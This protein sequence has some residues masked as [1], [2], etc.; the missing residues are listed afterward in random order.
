MKVLFQGTAVFILFFFVL[1]AC[2]K[3]THSSVVQQQLPPPPPPAPPTGAAP[4]SG[5]WTG[6]I[7][8]TVQNPDLCSWNGGT[9]SITQNW[10]VVGDSVHVEDILKDNGGTYTYYWLGTIKKDTL[11]MI[12]KRNINCFGEVKSNEIVVKA[13]ISSLVDKYSIQTSALYSPCPPD[14]IFEFNFMISKAK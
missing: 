3:D 5:K 10:I 6:T 14:C 1:P 7:I 9:V 11:E 12:S 4:Y 13:P 8:V 2:K